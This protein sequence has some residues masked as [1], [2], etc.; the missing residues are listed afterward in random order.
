MP[1]KFDLRFTKHVEEI[2]K[3]ACPANVFLQGCCFHFVR[4]IHFDREMPAIEGWTCGMEIPH[5]WLLAADCRPIDVEGVHERKPFLSAQWRKASCKGSVSR[6][7][8]E[9]IMAKIDAKPLRSDIAAQVERLALDLFDTDES[10]TSVRPM[11]T[12]R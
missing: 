2:L 8:M 10:F 7:G 5:V 9:R 12:G 3:S 6:I 1:E 4:R 11:P